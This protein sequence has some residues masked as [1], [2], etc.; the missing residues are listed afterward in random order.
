LGSRF[1]CRLP[2]TASGSI[3]VIAAAQPGWDDRGG[4]DFP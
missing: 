1:S 3:P 2:E 4:V